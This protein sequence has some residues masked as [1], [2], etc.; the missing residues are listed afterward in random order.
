MTFGSWESSGAWLIPYVTMDGWS[1]E[2][3]TE[4]LAEDGG[5]SHEDWVELAQLFVGHLGD[6]NVQRT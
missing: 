2:E 3:C 4:I 5:V 6:G 1:V